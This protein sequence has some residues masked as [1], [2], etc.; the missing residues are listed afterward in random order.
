MNTI[1]IL[2]SL[3]LFIPLHKINANNTNHDLQNTIV[4]VEENSQNIFSYETLLSE[5]Y[6]KVLTSRI[7]NHKDLISYEDFKTNYYLTN[8]NISQ[9]ESLCSNIE[10]VSAFEDYYNANTISSEEADYILDSNTYSITPDN[11]FKRDLIYSNTLF[12]ELRVGDIIYETLN[13]FLS[14]GHVA[15]I[16]NI[17]KKSE[18]KGSYIETIEAIPNKVQHG[19]LDDERMTKFGVRILR[20][21]EAYI[22]NVIEFLEKQLNKNYDLDLKRT[23]TSINS[24]EWYCSEL[25]WAAYLYAGIDICTVNKT[26]LGMPGNAGGPLPLTI[27]VGDYTYEISISP[28]LLKTSIVNKSGK[29][30]TIRIFNQNSFG[31]N[32]SYNSKMCYLKDAY[33]WENLNH[34]KYVYVNSYSYADIQISENWFATSIACSWTNDKYRYITYST[35]LNEN[36]KKITTRY[37]VL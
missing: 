8:L 27:Y 15:V 4:Q 34:I 11:V 12:Q 13:S 1:T 5:S 18:S 30:W 14:S 25:V 21:T 20:V 35:D 7:N 6:D 26:P 36:A 9:Y 31:V 24:N 16:T 23:N 32:A 28:Y 10:S 22:P 19:F 17:S 37:A 2:L 33:L 29:V 3:L